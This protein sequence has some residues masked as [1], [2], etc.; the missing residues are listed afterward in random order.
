MG[1][2]NSTDFPVT[3]GAFGSLCGLGGTCAAGHVTKLNPAGTQILWSTYVGDARQ[4]GSDAFFFTG[5]VQLDGSG[6]VYIMGQSGGP[7]FPTVNPVEP[8]PAGGSQE[9]LVAELDPTGTK[10]LFASRIGSGGI[11]TANPAGLA[12]DSAGNIYLAGN[13]IGQGLNTT[14]GAFQT[15]SNDSAGCCY[16]GFVAKIS[17]TS[18]PQ[19]P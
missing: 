9:V 7:G 8:T 13:I 16:H 10:L 11:H 15:G 19:S 17:A 1:Y 2:T 5:P 4:D 12:V 14:P 18:T 3:A 6:N